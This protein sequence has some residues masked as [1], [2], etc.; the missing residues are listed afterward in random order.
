MKGRA[1]AAGLTLTLLVSACGTTDATHDPVAA[2]I[3]GH[4]FA[5]RQEARLNCYSPLIGD[6]SVLPGDYAEPVR[7]A[8]PLG[9][10]DD[11]SN[12]ARVLPAGTEFV[13]MEVGWWWAITGTGWSIQGRLVAPGWEDEPVGL[14]YVFDCPWPPWKDGVITCNEQYARRVD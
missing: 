5:L 13:V 7:S 6:F 1:R 2:E 11:D 3:V 12:L 8:V 10:P 14:N 4:R 9:S